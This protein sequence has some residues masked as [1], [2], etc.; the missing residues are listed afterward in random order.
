VTGSAT[1]GSEDC[2]FLNMLIPDSIDGNENRPVMIWIHGGA[3]VSGSGHGNDV[4]QNQAKYTDGRGLAL[5]ED[6]IVV[7]MNYRLGTVG[8]LSG[9]DNDHR[10]NF[11]VRD[12]QMAIKWVHQNIADFGGD[13]SRIT[14][15]GCSAGGRSV[16]AQVITPYNQGSKFLINI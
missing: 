12:Q 16:G 6:V 2:L 8:F 9:I 14:I 13:P 3:F 5:T 7:N 4:P 11:G 10:G 1:H 15:F